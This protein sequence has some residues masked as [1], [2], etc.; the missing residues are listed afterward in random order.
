M[1]LFSL[2]MPRPSLNTSKRKRPIGLALKRQKFTAQ[3]PPTGNYL[4]SAESLCKSLQ[5]MHI[6]TT[7]CPPE[8]FSL[9][10][11]KD[12]RSGIFASLEVEC[13]CC[14]YSSYLDNATRTGTA[15]KDGGNLNTALCLAADVVGLDYNGLERFCH[16]MGLDGPPDYWDEVYQKKIRDTLGVMIDEQLTKNRAES[17]R[18]RD[19]DGTTAVQISI[20]ADGTYQ[21]RGSYIF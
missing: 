13:G 17:H 14:G 19:S 15:F 9:T 7:K 11:R 20:K 4:V 6:S 12:E 16:V 2:V 21:K 10:E 5:H 1:L 18:S 3:P 8:A